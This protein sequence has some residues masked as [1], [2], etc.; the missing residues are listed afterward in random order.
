M[1]KRVLFKW[2]TLIEYM[3]TECNF[4]VSSPQNVNSVSIYSSSCCS[5][6][7]FRT[8]I[9]I[10]LIKSESWITHYW[11]NLHFG[12]NYPFNCMLFAFNENV[13]YSLLTLNVSTLTLVFFTPTSKTSFLCNFIITFMFGMWKFS[14]ANLWLINKEFGPFLEN[15]PWRE[16]IILPVIDFMGYSV[17][18]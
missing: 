6:P 13:V 15:N 10:F 14:S 4:C 18:A 1:W 5:N 7:I 12:V 9:K 3:Q 2:Y 16:Y 8:E 17:K 11:H